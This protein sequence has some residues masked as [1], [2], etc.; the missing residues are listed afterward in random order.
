MNILYIIGILLSV[1]C[2]IMAVIDKN[3]SALSIAGWATA[4]I[5]E[6]VGLIENVRR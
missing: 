3:V 6:L 2:L 1:V 5:W 4:I